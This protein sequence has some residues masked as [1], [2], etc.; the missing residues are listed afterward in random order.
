LI[1]GKITPEIKYP[2]NRF[3]I[4]LYQLFVNFVIAQ[5]VHFPQGYYI[6]W[7]GQF[8][9]LKAAE[10]RLAI[11][12][13]FTLLI[14]FFL[15]YLYT[16]SVIKTFVVLLSVPFSLVGAFWMLFLLHYSG[17]AI[18]L[19]FANSEFTFSNNLRLKIR[20]VPSF[21]VNPPISSEAPE[22]VSQ[23]RFRL[24]SG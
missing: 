23:R 10:G 15:I 17:I 1:H 8:K 4:W 9:Y 2:L 20:I 7:A 24:L 22:R 3:L 11:L 13:P 19:S 5:K 6:Q 18:P 14:I 16:R 21:P 12:V